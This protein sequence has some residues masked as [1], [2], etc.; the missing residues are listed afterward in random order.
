VTAWAEKPQIFKTVVSPVAVDVIQFER[1][2]LTIPFWW[3]AADLTLVLDQLLSLQKRLQLHQI[4]SAS[5]SGF[6]LFDEL[7]K[8][9]ERVF[10]ISFCQNYSPKIK[11]DNS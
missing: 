6:L 9:I 10:P 4:K 7:L 5:P 3:Y 2:L 8:L 11:S 1:Q